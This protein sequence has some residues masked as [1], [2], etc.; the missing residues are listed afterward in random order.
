[1]S[2]ILNE[3]VEATANIIAQ[4]AATGHLLDRLLL[5]YGEAR[6]MPNGLNACL[7]TIRA[8]RAELEA[9][10]PRIPG[11]DAW[12]APHREQFETD[13]LLR[14]AFNARDKTAHQ[15]DLADHS[16][17]R[18][19][20]VASYRAAPL[21]S[22]QP[23]SVFASGAEIVNT[24]PQE[25]LSP[26]VRENGVV[27]ISRRWVDS[28][29]PDWEIVGALDTVHSRLVDIVADLYTHCG[30][31]INPLKQPQVDVLGPDEDRR[32]Y[33]A[34]KD[35]LYQLHSERRPPPADELAAEVEKMLAGNTLHPSLKAAST[36]RE[37]ARIYFEYMS[38]ALL[39]TGR[40]QPAAVFFR[41]AGTITIRSLDL[42]SRAH[43]Y[44]VVHE[45]AELSRQIDADGVIF[46]VE[47][48]AGAAAKL[49][50]GQVPGKK[51][52]IGEAL[53][54]QGAAADGTV[55]HLC[56]NIHRGFFRRSKVKHLDPPFEES[57][58]LPGTMVPFLEM[59]GRLEALN[60]P[61]DADFT[62]DSVSRG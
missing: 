31:D 58:D 61:A 43:K 35:G 39:R 29:L 34:V 3:T 19:D 51:T 44:A 7:K 5:I 37:A 41:G 6:A 15:R 57:R 4:V 17:V 32:L 21:A 56:S 33:L 45:F 54:M 24:I 13:P 50:P 23:G 36:F 22:W 27:R 11:F 14:W 28:E 1:M 12:Y 62:R 42:A 38:E 55:I 30:V 47:A 53:V 9:V 60:L 59:W 2:K 10:A 46:V 49:A 25:H 40:V 18:V 52:A 48:W 16:R 20:L 8:S 26:H